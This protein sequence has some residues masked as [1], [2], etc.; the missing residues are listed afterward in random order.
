MVKSVSED[1][2]PPAVT[3]TGKKIVIK[4][5][6]MFGDVQKEAIDVAIAVSSIFS[7]AIYLFFFFLLIS[8]LNFIFGL[9]FFLMIFC[10][11]LY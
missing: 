5:A 10:G 1:R 2:K 6:D 11:F 4:S 3:A 7:I 9:L 8:Y